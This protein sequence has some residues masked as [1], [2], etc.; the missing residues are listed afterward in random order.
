LIKFQN[1]PDQHENG[2]D[3]SGVEY[4]GQLGDGANRLASQQDSYN[5]IAVPC[6][7]PR[8]PVASRELLFDVWGPGPFGKQPAGILVLLVFN[9][10]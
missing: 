7:T 1:F 4:D 6:R 9:G 3:D 8:I 10:A 5:W 2:L